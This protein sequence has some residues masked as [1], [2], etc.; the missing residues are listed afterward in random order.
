M[1]E[2]DVIVCFGDSSRFVCSFVV[3][4]N[5]AAKELHLNAVVEVSV[6]SEPEDVSGN[7]M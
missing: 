3:L 1:A 6:C 2:A 7:L 5:L 4:K